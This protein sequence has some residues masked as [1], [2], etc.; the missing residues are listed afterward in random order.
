M[1]SRFRHPRFSW[2]TSSRANKALSGATSANPPIDIR[3]N[4]PIVDPAFDILNSRPRVLT[5][6]SYRCIDPFP[7]P[8]A[9]ESPAKAFRSAVK[10]RVTVC[11]ERHAIRRFAVPPSLVAILPSLWRMRSLAPRVIVRTRNDV[12]AHQHF[13]RSVRLPAIFE[14]PVFMWVLSAT[15][16]TPVP[17]CSPPTSSKCFVTGTFV[18]SPIETKPTTPIFRRFINFPRSLSFGWRSSG[19]LIVVTAKLGP[20]RNCD[21]PFRV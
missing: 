15:A 14:K 7:W 6:R 18:K 5:W 16:L 13:Y 12:S 2:R 17:N 3:H 9:K 19:I 1:F 4:S 11:S 10:Y 21:S 20:S 8:H